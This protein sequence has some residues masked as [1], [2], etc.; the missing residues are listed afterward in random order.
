MKGVT[1]FFMVLASLWLGSSFYFGLT[2]SHRRSVNSDRF[3]TLTKTFVTFLDNS[4]AGVDPKTAAKDPVR[5]EKA[6][7]LYVE[8]VNDLVLQSPCDFKYRIPPDPLSK[9]TP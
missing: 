6:R 8:L 4:L 1:A 5:F 9:G 3:C 2:A 7:N